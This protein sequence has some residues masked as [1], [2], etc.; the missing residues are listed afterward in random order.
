MFVDVS[1]TLGFD[2]AWL[3]KPQKLPKAEANMHTNAKPRAALAAPRDAPQGAIN[4]GGINPGGINPGIPSPDLQERIAASKAEALARRRFMEVLAKASLATSSPVL[5]VAENVDIA[6]VPVPGPLP[7]TEPPEAV[8]LTDAATTRD[9]CIICL[10]PLSTAPVQ[11]MECMH[12]FHK[13]CL[14]EHMRH[15]FTAFRFAC[16]FKCFS[17]GNMIEIGASQE[18]SGPLS[19]V[20]EQA[21]QDTEAI[22]VDADEDVLV[23]AERTAATQMPPDVD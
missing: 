21:N 18:T 13:E 9:Q 10:Q 16:P 12:V 4:P 5:P 11:A 1:D 7:P 14:E 23:V 19:N 15:T 8:S 20:N 6:P 22:A 3:G 17:D 2:M